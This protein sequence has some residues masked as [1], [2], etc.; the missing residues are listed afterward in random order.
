MILYFYNCQWR[1]CNLILPAAACAFASLSD[2]PPFRLTPLSIIELSLFR[3]MTESSLKAS[4]WSLR[5]AVSSARC[6]KCPSLC[7]ISERR[8]KIDTR[9]RN[10]RNL[11]SN[12]TYFEIFCTHIST[13]Y[14]LTH[15]LDGE[16]DSR[17]FFPES[18]AQA[19][20]QHLNVFSY[21]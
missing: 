10:N 12:N 13:H 5:A 6:R 16:G 1:I 19:L 2:I 9:W 15:F 17:T 3:V 14:L 18:E 7:F 4:T 21:G 8:K 20:P 11:F